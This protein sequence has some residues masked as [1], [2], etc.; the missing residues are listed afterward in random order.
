MAGLP[1]TVKQAICAFEID[2]GGESFTAA[3]GAGTITVTATAGCSWQA[4]N[5]L[6]FVLLVGNTI[7][8][9][10]GTV[11]F[12]VTA[13]AGVDRAGTFTVAGLPF[14]VQQQS[15]SLTGWPNFIGS[16]PHI[17]AEEIGPRNLRWSTK[18]CAWRKL[19]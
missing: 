10:S 2:P 5:T 19:A 17:A 4:I 8:I 13:D 14:T 9:G 16:M 18:A 1:V 11:N 3:G 7:G 12:T 6:P 15:A